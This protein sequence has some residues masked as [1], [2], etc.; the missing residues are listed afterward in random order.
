MCRIGLKAALSVTILFLNFIEPVLPQAREYGLPI[1]GLGKYEVF[2][3]DLLRNKYVPVPQASHVD[4]IEEVSC[5][6]TMCTAEWLS[7]D[8]H[9]LTF[10]IWFQ[11]KGN[12]QVFYLAPQVD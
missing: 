12:K 6:N 1:S 7:P 4:G 2:R 5:G 3:R 9:K 10:V 11:Y 8:R